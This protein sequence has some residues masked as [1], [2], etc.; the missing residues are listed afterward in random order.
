MNEFWTKDDEQNRY[1]QAE[2][3]KLKREL[4]K[5]YA[6]HH[7]CEE[8]VLEIIGMAAAD[9]CDLALEYLDDRYS[10]K[11]TAALGNNF[12]AYLF[13]IEEEANDNKVDSL[14]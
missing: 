1:H 14:I 5:D 10:A 8:T 12:E 9:D 7:N 4:L 13:A 2:M 3:K 11:E 6:F